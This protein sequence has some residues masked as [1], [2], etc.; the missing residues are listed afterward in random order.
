MN[1]C[2]PLNQS[3][4]SNF[5][6][7]IISLYI[8]SIKLLNFPGDEYIALSLVYI[9]INLVENESYLKYIKF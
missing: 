5:V 7:Y 9:N 1:N 6:M 8:D 3:D 2:T 4:C